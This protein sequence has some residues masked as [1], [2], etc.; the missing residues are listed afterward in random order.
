MHRTIGRMVLDFTLSFLCT[1]AAE[2]RGHPLC[3]KITNL[4]I[5]DVERAP[6]GDAKA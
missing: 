6:E 4:M 3:L 1:F 5:S 2:K